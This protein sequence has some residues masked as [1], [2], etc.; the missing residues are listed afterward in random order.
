G[1]QLIKN[2]KVKDFEAE[3]VTK[4]GED[5]IWK[6]S[7]EI[8]QINNEK[9]ILGIIEDVTEMRIAELELKRQSEFIHTMTENQPAG[10]VACDAVGK[11]VLFN[12][13][14][15]E[16]HGIDILKISQDQWAENYGLYRE[17]GKTILE[18]DDIPLIK[19]FKG[20]KVEN[21][22][23]VIKAVGQKPRLVSCNGASFFEKSGKRLGAVIVMTDITQERIIENNLKKSESDLRKALMEVERNE[24]LLNEAGRMAKIGA[25]EFDLA[26]QEIRWSD[27][28]FE[29]HGIAK[30]EVPDFDFIMSCYIDGSEEILRNAIEEC[31]NQKKKYELELRFE[32]ARKEKLWVKAIGYPIMNEKDEIVSLRGVVQDITEQKKKEN[33]LKFSEKRFR[34][35][36]EGAPDPIFIQTNKCFAYLNKHAVN[37]F[38]AKD[39]KELIGK[40]VLDF[41]HPDFHK[42]A[43]ERIKKLNSDKTLVPEPFEQILI[44]LNGKEVW[45]ETKGEPIFFNN[46]NGGL[47]FI[48][49]ISFR[50]NAEKELRDSEKRYKTLFENQ[51]TII[52]EEDFSDLK[53]QFDDLKKEGVED[54]N[55]YFDQHPEVVKELAAKVKVVEVNSTGIEILEAESKEDIVKNI[56]YYFDSDEAWL[57]FK[58]ELV[59]L[60]HGEVSFQCEIPI[61]TVKGNSKTLYLKLIVHPDYT[62]DL[63]KV[64]VTF[65][66]IS[67]IKK[68]EKELRDSEYKLKELLN[69]LDSGI[70]IHAA[71]TSIIFN[72]QKAA[73]ILR[74]SYDKI[75]GKHVFDYPWNFLNED[76]SILS[77]EDYPVNQILKRK[78]VIK[79][80]VIGMNHK[81]NTI[82]AILSGF[83]V[84]N[85]KRE[86][87]EVVT[88]FI[89]ITAQVEANLRLT[90]NEAELKMALT[91]IERSEFFLNET[92]KLSKIGGWDLDLTT[93][94]PYFSEETYRIY[95]IPHGKPPKLEDGILFYPIEARELV[96][97]AVSDA[98]EKHINYDIEVPFI[99]AKGKHIWVRTIGQVQVKEGVAIR[100]FGTI[101]DITNLKKTQLEIEKTNDLLEAIT[102]NLPGAVIQYKMNSDGSDALTYVSSG[103][104]E[105]WG[106]KPEEALKDN[107]K[108]WNQIDKNSIDEVNDSLQK[109]YL[110]LSPWNVEFK[111]KLP[112]GKNKWIQGIG[113]PKKID[114][115]VIWSSIML[116]I[117][118]RKEADES[119]KKYQESLQK[120]TIELSL[121]EEKQRKDIAANI[122]DHLSQSLVIS[123]M[124]V[125]EFI[126]KNNSSLNVQD[127]TTVIQHLS[128]AIENSRKITYDLSPPVLY[129]LGL[130]ET[131]YWLAEKT[132]KEHG[133]KVSFNTNQEYLKLSEKELILI[134]RTIQELINNTIK[135]AKAT[136]LIIKL[137][138]QVTLFEILIADNG[139]GFDEDLGI[140]TEKNNTGFGLFSVKERIQNLFGTIDFDTAIGKGTRVKITFP[141]NS[142]KYN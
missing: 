18:M 115:S 133:L 72:N 93:M 99:T 78:E 59:A 82:W 60:A 53:K 42:A 68:A 74:S 54:F 80:M 127:L 5:R 118:N 73:E 3:F 11:L 107:S 28:V 55:I 134:F 69:N 102:N 49:D 142:S 108:I 51:P 110:N 57:K 92:G 87:I 137:N 6:T 116:D 131:L 2:G 81:E 52:W 103:S 7:G 13:A 75:T 129:E 126:K 19:A 84:F 67:E 89:D 23:M 41:F 4:S 1:Q 32:N 37:L 16:W 48:R 46:E 94:T 38:G 125:R 83:P 58:E 9:Y 140:K 27:Q 21:Y 138:I 91:E 36:I 15:K 33:E 141:L 64:V 117:T 10:I 43:L 65:Q 45:V 56:P 40:P 24:F 85:E 39:E 97:K 113:T 61:R 70:V 120:L 95:E 100:L 114:D 86:I 34:A 106:I 130:I 29:L 96:Q 139:I 71:D 132:Q 44:K 77:L 109:S 50:K 135:H 112:N 88:S 31:I 98:I 30:G 25:W 90:E 122:H 47:V 123:K 8:V 12:K 136:E 105:I 35:M 14:A 79:N 119:I 63:K 124:K 76:G 62:N 20:K 128:D 66:D 101:Q 22:E 17:D 121:I 26:T 111:S 104:N